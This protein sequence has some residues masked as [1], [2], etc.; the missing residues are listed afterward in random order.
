MDNNAFA[1]Q[2]DLDTPLLDIHIDGIVK[3]V[4]T[5]ECQ[6]KNTHI[7]NIHEMLNLQYR[8]LKLE[9]KVARH[10]PHYLKKITHKTYVQYSGPVRAR[11]ARIEYHE[12]KGM[13]LNYDFFYV[14]KGHKFPIDSF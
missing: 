13:I 1:V 7:S 2:T 10:L 8:S 11:Q 9:K 5:I 3:Q 6:L 12:H 14:P 4:G